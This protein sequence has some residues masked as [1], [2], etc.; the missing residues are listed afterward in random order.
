MTSH[1]VCSCPRAASQQGPY[2]GRAEA[3]DT[4]LYLDWPRDTCT[5]HYMEDL[6][7]DITWFS[8]RLCRLA[9]AR[10]GE[11]TRKKRDKETFILT[12]SDYAMQVWSGL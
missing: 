12:E 11:I 4:S 9:M 6:H 7:T 1:L 3:W 10:V 5:H 2:L 8:L